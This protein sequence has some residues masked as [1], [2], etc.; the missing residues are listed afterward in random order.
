MAASYVVDA[1]VL[2]QGFLKDIHTPQVRV[3]LSRMSQ[4]DQLYVPEFCLLE[5]TNVIRK[6]VRF[7]S[8]PQEEAEQ[9]IVDLAKL[10]ELFFS[11]AKLLKNF[12]E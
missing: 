2:I 5:C 4:G 12:V 7:Q 3:L 1:S 11:N 8:L 9:L 10:V 6:Y